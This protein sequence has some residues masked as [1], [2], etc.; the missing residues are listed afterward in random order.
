MVAAVTWPPVGLL[1]D[2]HLGGG[3]TLVS[4]MAQIVFTTYQQEFVTTLF[5]Q[6]LRV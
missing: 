4:L 5:S 1:Y 6:V 2:P 3:K